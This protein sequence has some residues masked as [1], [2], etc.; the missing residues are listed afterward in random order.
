MEME[1]KVKE[2]Y[3]SYSKRFSQTRHAI[4][5]VIIDFNKSI[6]PNSKIL[7]INNTISFSTLEASSITC[8]ILDSNSPLYFV[9]AIN[10][11]ISSDKILLSFIEK[12]TFH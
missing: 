3:N 5:D 11:D 7:D 10:E 6:K 12:G 2:F 9:Q 4:W 1:N 8:L